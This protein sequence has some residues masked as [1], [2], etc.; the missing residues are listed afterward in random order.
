MNGSGLV[1]YA[2]SDGLLRLAVEDA[3]STLRRLR[4][5]VTTILLLHAYD[6]CRVGNASLSGL[7]LR[8]ETRDRFEQVRRVLLVFL[9]DEAHIC[10]AGATMVGRAPQ[11]WLDTR[12]HRPKCLFPNLSC[13]GL[14]WTVAG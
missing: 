10:M 1:A 11:F 9:P 7:V 14:A 13:K 3:A 8:R 6:R 12:R 2:L 5:T 4:V